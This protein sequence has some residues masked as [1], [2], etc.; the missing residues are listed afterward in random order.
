M[1]RRRR[2]SRIAWAG[3]LIAAG[4]LSVVPA[5][6]ADLVV[7]V[8]GLSSDAGKVHFGLYDDPAA[9]PEDEGRLDGTRVRIKDHR[10]IAVFKDLRPGRYAVAVYHDENDNGEFDQAL[11]GIPLE[12]FG[13]SND[14]TVF[15]G[16]PSFGEAQVS[17]P[18]EG[19]RITIHMD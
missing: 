9:F 15:L 7:E 12:D 16:P 18:E 13:F 5:I 19:A 11:F 14:A 2:V 1:T 3:G 17:V 4:A 6:A 10:A 8:T